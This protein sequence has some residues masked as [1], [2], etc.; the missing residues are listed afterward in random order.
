MLL[1]GLSR[2][3][4]GQLVLELPDGTEEAFGT[5]PGRPSRGPVRIRVRDEAFFGRL[6]TGGETGAGESYILGEWECDDL[7]RLIEMAIRNR[8]HLKR[9]VPLFWVGAVG[10]WIGH[11]LRPNTRTGSR[12]N[13]HA[14]YDL[15]NEF[16]EVFLDPSMTYSSAVFASSD[17]SLE[18]AQREKYRRMAALAAIRPGDHVLEVGCGWGGFAEFA[19]TDLGCR[20]TGLTISRAQAEY[21]RTR[22]RDA[23]LDDRVAIDVRDYRDIEGKYD[24]IVSIEMLEAVG[25]RYLRDYFEALDGALAPG[26]RA[27]V[28]V[29]TIPDERYWRYRLRPDF[30]QKFIF[31]GAHLPSVR[32]MTGALAGTSLRLIGATD[33]APHYA[34]T[35]RLWRRSFLANADRIRAQGFDDDFIRRWDFYFAYCEAGFAARYVGDQQLS[36]AR[37]GEASRRVLD[38]GSLE[39]TPLRIGRTG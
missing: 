4:D 23:G 19:A 35:L 18:E 9:G 5:T 24:A 36:L 30:I 13:I 34:E 22:M 15:G 27:A 6:L 21:A 29:I 14:H 20:V 3:R 7:P 39:D 32:A 1:R 28:Q 10:D 8:S 37:P 25:H 33:V 31:P 17:A 11:R 38:V 2:W 12:R 26:G 16:F